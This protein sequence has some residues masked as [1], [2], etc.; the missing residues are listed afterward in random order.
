MMNVYVL[1]SGAAL[2]AKGRHCSAQVVAVD[3]RR[4]LLDCGEGAQTQ[5]RIAHQ[6]LQSLN[7]IFIS[8]LHGD[9]LFGLPGLLSTMHMC[10]RKDPVDIYAPAGLKPAL[11]LLFEVSGS[12]IDFEMRHHELASDQ[13]EVLIEDAKLRVTAFP[14]SHS[15]PAYGY[16]FQ[17]LSLRH[18]NSYAYCCDTGYTEQFLPV[19]KGVD[20]LCLESTFM[21]DYE[22]VAVEKGHLTAPQAAT[23]AL[24]A[25][26][27]QLMLT[28]FSA[29]YSDIEPL[30]AEARQVF[31]NTIPAIE[32]RMIEVRHYPKGCEPQLENHQ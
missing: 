4:F 30:L 5:L 18:P 23:L 10:G 11:D 13:P 14:L 9:H 19:V 21:S 32:G 7:H 3:G 28:H 26:A 8:H 31:P 20:L 2:P 22:P 27:R 12:H 1:G 16:H 25:E 29:R 6:K 24:K 17:E 15:V